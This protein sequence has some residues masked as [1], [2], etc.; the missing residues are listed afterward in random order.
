M[1]DCDVAVI[2]AGPTGLALALDLARRGV[3]VRIFDRVPEPFAGSRGKVVTVRTQE[4]LDDFGIVDRLREAGF[5]HL[6][7]R[8]YLRGVMV[9]DYDPAAGGLPGPGRPFDYGP[10]FIPQWRLEHLLRDAL[11]EFGV[12]VEYG[13]ELTD[14]GQSA[15]AVTLQLAGG[16]SIQTGWLVGCDGAHSTVRKRLGLS[17]VGPVDGGG[18]QGMLLG[19]VRVDGLAPDRW[20]QWSDPDR[21]FVALCPFRGSDTWQFQGGLFADLGPDGNWP[22]PG[23][24]RFQRT[25]DAVAG[26]TDIRLSQPTWL[27]TWRVNVRMVERLRVGRVLV[28]GDAAHVHPPA[29]GLGMNTGIQDAYNL[30]WKLGWVLNGADPQLLDSYQAERLPIAQWTLGVSTESLHQ[31]DSD[32]TDGKFDGIAATASRDVH[33]LRLGYPWSPLAVDA[34][35]PVSTVT[36]GYRAPDALCQYPDG[37]PVRIFDLFRG[38]HFTVLGFGPETAPAVASIT[39]TDVRG[40]VVGAGGDRGVDLVDV[41][42]AARRA[43]GV[44]GAALLLI[45]PDGYVGVTAAPADAGA[46]SNYLAPLAD[47]RRRGGEG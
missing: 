34:S 13:M 19:D 47:T 26:R 5:S 23:V 29:G 35:G 25:L 20:Y 21:G 36:A 27:S 24:D 8:V 1:P 30:G 15:D 2:G 14:F 42:G 32:L 45:R 18:M 3:P 44:D 9:R 46:V 6:W 22:A 33:Q 11:T 28:A 12:H 16:E 4:V 41:D 43:Y 40:V 39:G 38:P 37:A 17:F 10:V 7:H 31:L